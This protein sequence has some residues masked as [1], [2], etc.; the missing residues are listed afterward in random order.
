[1]P[2]EIQFRFHQGYYQPLDSV[3]LGVGKA[4][5]QD[6]GSLGM[7]QRWSPWVAWRRAPNNLCIEYGAYLAKFAR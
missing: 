4:N 7:S 2:I 3:L 5:G 1:M 6:K